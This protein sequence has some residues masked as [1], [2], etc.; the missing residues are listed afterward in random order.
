MSRGGANLIGQ[1]RPSD[2]TE[3]SPVSE[4]A[5]IAGSRR[6]LPT[7]VTVL[8]FVVPLVAY[9]WFIHHYGVNMIWRDQWSDIGLLSHS[10]SHTLDL[11]TLWQQHNEN[12]IF[13]PNLIVLLLAGTTH[14]N[15]V[16]EEYLSGLM[17]VV[18]T[19]LFIVAHK[20]RN[21]GQPWIYYLP[22]A[23]LMLSFG[24]VTDTL[25]GFQMA[26]YLVLLMLAA[27]LFLL[28][29]PRFS[30]IA[31]A[32]AVAAAIIGSFSSLQGLLI[33]PAG[34]AL[35]YC[36]RRPNAVMVTW[37]ACALATGILYCY[38][39]SYHSGFATPNFVT[40]HPMEAVVYFLA[41]IGLTHEVL[42]LVLLQV[43]FWVVITIGLRRDE[44]GGSPIGV[45]LV[46]FGLLFALSITYGR[47]WQQI[48]AS[49]YAAFDLLIP[50]GC[51]LALLNPATRRRNA[52]Q[53]GEIFHPATQVAPTAWP[54]GLTTENLRARA[55]AWVDRGPHL[56]AIAVLLCAMSVQVILGTSDGLHSARVLHQDQES[57]AHATVNIETADDAAV[58]KEVYFPAYLIR[59]WAQIART[60]HLSLFEASPVATTRGEH[61]RHPTQ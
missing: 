42:G 12:R 49:R 27:T 4:S 2:G 6:S 60:H 47:G 26:W 7:S 35:L 19:V 32:C 40:H 18:A 46:C 21:A 56:V 55:S 3:A 24:Q 44:T 28:D 1:L 16:F 30:W 11:S 48:P 37:I 25:W 38:H 5:P 50:V 45:A 9:F 41:A 17:L 22:V 10:Y 15:I 39:L 61:D 33:W 20:R 13:F 59:Q 23:V 8:A 52:R 29:M 54:S 57:T 36:R 34:L 58:D 51:Y 14:F 43:A 31:V 53:Q